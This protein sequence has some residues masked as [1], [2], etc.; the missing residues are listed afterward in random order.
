VLLNKEAVRTI[1]IWSSS[2]N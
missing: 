2:F 1:H